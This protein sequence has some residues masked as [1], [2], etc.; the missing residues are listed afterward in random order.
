MPGLCLVYLS[1]PGS[2]PGWL[3]L[4]RASHWS[5]RS[6]DP[7]TLTLN[8]TRQLCP[9]EDVQRVWWLSHCEFVQQSVHTQHWSG[10][11]HVVYT[12]CQTKLLSTG[13]HCTPLSWVVYNHTIQQ[14]SGLYKKV[15]I[16]KEVTFMYSGRSNNALNSPGLGLLARPGL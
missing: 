5:M 11:D 14:H 6:V 9:I 3:T 16:L 12:V 15:V 7:V 8:P 13:E 4:S 1:M 10:A 2:M